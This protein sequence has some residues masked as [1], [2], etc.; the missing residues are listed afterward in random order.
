LSGV[1]R[2]FALEPLPNQSNVA[3]EALKPAFI[4]LPCLTPAVLN[5]LHEGVGR[6]AALLEVLGVELQ[7]VGRRAL[8]RQAPRVQRGDRRAA[9]V[10]KTLARLSH[11]PAVEVFL[12]QIL[13]DLRMTQDITALGTATADDKP[14]QRREQA[15]RRKRWGSAV[16]LVCKV[17]QMLPLQRAVGASENGEDPLDRPVVNE[18]A[19][20]FPGSALQ[21]E[22]AFKVGSETG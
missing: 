2:G 6:C 20:L 17:G 19:L 16:Q 4:G 1:T 10:G 21:S 18:E 9:P 14:A 11:R 7:K 13:T 22:P 3:G 15:R 8:R 12:T 5:Q